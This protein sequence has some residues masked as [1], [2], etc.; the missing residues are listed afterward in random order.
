VRELPPLDV[1]L[2]AI[3]GP[4]ESVRF[5]FVPDRLAPEARPEPVDWRGTD[6]FMVRGPFAAEDR[7]CVVPPPLR[8]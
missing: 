3:G 1:L 5:R 6:F 4:L 8:H 2:A 7:P